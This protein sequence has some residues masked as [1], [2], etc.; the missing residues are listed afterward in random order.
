M[1]AGLAL[2]W[3]DAEAS[4]S[5]NGALPGGGSVSASGKGSDFDTL[6]GGYARADAVYDLGK[7]WRLLGG[8]QFQSLGKYDHNFGGREVELDLRTSIFVTVGLGVSF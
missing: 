1:S 3:L 6:W 7:Q 4:W 2:G 5:E 8:V